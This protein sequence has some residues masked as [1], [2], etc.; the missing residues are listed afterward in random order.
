LRAFGPAL[1]DLTSSAPADTLNEPVRC[2][3]ETVVITLSETAG[4]S[5]SAPPYPDGAL[6]F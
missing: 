6:S 3:A 2:D 4:I 5:A 1:N